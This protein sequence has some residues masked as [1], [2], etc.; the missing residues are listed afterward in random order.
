ML[1]VTMKC[2]R[3]GEE[4]ITE[5]DDPTTQTVEAVVE[6]MKWRIIT[7]DPLTEEERTDMPDHSV[8]HTVLCRTCADRH[9]AA[10]LAT[11]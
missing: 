1:D 4:V 9:F 2:D 11:E 3:C 8:M 7:T 10:Y 5:V 6:T